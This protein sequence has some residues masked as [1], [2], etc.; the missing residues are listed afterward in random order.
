MNYRFQ[1][2]VWGGTY[3]ESPHTNGIIVCGTDKGGI[4]I[5]NPDKILNGE[6][7]CM[8]LQT[9]KHT[10]PVGALDFNPFQVDFRHGVFNLLYVVF[11]NNC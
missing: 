6:E 1:K 9:S 4:E 5:Y 8:V 2:V 11:L 3:S 10:G 7:D